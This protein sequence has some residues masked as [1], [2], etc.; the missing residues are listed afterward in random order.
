MMETW[1]TIGILTLITFA[2]RFM[3]L[4]ESVHFKPGPRVRRFLSYSVYAILTSIWAPIL[5]KLEQGSLTIAGLDYLLATVAAAILTL[6]RLPSI[7]VVLLSA[8]VFVL[9]RSLL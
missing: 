1:F 5:F 6:L 7:A 2:N 4:A 3:F 8:S 9:M